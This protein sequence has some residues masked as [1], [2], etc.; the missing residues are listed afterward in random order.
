MNSWFIYIYMQ[1]FNSC[2][3]TV[4]KLLLAF[5]AGPIL[6]IW[7]VPESDDIVSKLL[8]EEKSIDLAWHEKKPR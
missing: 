1:L 4:F 7:T 5:N 3:R 6:K 2:L 8:S